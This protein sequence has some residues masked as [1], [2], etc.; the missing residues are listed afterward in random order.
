MQKALR[1]GRVLVD[2]SQ[3]DEHKTTVNVYSLR[4]KETPT[5][6]TPVT[7]K[8]VKK[9]LAAKDAKLLSFTSEQVLARVKKHGDLFE[10]VLT[11]KQKL[12]TLSKM[13][14]AISA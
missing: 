2:W 14:E 3:N 7:W 12:P 5:V 9:C 8:E 11:L 13:G 4:A 6:S 1:K 10:P